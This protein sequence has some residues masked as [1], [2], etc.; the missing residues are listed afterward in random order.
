MEFFWDTHNEFNKT[1]QW[2]QDLNRSKKLGKWQ[3]DE[4]EMN[5][6]DTTNRSVVVEKTEV[7]NAVTNRCL[8]GRS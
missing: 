7:V 3:Y 8:N 4:G 5:V 2:M 6:F 1:L